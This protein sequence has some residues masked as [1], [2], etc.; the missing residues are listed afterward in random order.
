MQ[1]CTRLDDG[2]VDREVIAISGH[3]SCP[4]MSEGIP[5]AYDRCV[6]EIVHDVFGKRLPND[7]EIGEIAAFVIAFD[8]GDVRVFSGHDGLLASVDDA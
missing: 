4:E 7:G 2:V 1:A 3:H 5:T 8:G 6:S